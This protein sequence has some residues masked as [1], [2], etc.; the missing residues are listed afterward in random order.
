MI[1]LLYRDFKYNIKYN[2]ITCL[3]IKNPISPAFST[4]LGQNNPPFYP[5]VL[6]NAEATSKGGLHTGIMKALKM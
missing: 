2:N 1:I 5:L 4:V 6:F 3:L